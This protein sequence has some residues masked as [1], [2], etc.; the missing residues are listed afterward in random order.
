MLFGHGLGKLMGFGQLAPVFPDP[1]GIGTTASLA[2]AVFA[3]VFCSACIMLG[4][5]TRFAAV[6]LIGTML[7]AAFLVHTMDPWP[8]KEFPL[9]YAVCFATLMLTG[10]GRISLDG[11]LRLRRTG[12]P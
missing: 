9:L 11:L 8:K 12:R 10:P 2:A 6:P 7:T 3:E 1:L 4:I 5:S